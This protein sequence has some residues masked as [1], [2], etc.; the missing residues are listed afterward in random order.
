MARFLALS[1]PRPGQKRGEGWTANRGWREV[2]NMKRVLIT[3][4]VM[5]AVATALAW[6]V[7]APSSLAAAQ[8]GAAGAAAP[9]NTAASSAVPRIDGH[10]DLSGVWWRGSDIGGRSAGGAPAA[11]RGGAPAGAR[12]GGRG[13]APPP[14]FTTLYQPWALEKAKTLGD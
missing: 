10:P 1:G 8:R 4:M 2:S 7:P 12:G 3:S 9:V 6:F 5:A 11:G 13:A 14:S